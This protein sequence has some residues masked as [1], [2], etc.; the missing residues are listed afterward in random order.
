MGLWLF[1]W[2]RK[3]MWFPESPGLSGPGA[4]CIGSGQSTP[5]P[6]PGLLRIGNQSLFSSSE[7]HI[8]IHVPRVGG[9]PPLPHCYKP[10]RMR[11]CLLEEQLGAP[12]VALTSPRWLQ[13]GCE[14]ASRQGNV[15]PHSCVPPASFRLS[16][17]QRYY[18]AV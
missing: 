11:M 2:I 13:G 18:M 16:S 10:S 7:C 1:R 5:E 15:P 8:R 12:R 9:G 4:V 17:S 3:K 14:R 6:S